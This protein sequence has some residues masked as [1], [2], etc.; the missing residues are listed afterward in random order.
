MNESLQ[1]WINKISLVFILLTSP[2]VFAFGSSDLPNEAYNIQCEENYGASPKAPSSVCNLD[3]VGAIVNANCNPAGQVIARIFINYTD[4]AGLGYLVINGQNFIPDNNTGT[5][6]FNILVTGDGTVQ[7]VYAEMELDP[8]CFA[9]ELNYLNTPNCG[10]NTGNCFIEIIEVDGISSCLPDGTVNVLVRVQYGNLGGGDIELDGNVFTPD[11]SGN[12]LFSINVLGDGTVGVD[13][14]AENT[15]DSSCNHTLV[16]AFNAPGCITCNVT[17]FNVGTPSVCNNGT[18]SIPVTLTYNNAAGNVDINGQIFTP[19]ASSGTE[20]FTLTNLPGNGTPNID[21][22]ATFTGDPNCTDTMLSAYNAPDCSCTLTI[23][24]IGTPSACDGSGNYSIGITVNYVGAQGNIDING[25]IFTPGG[26]SGTETFTLVNLPGNGA[27]NLPVTA[28]FTGDTNCTDTFNNAYDAPD[29]NCAITVVSVG[30]PSACDANGNFSINVTVSYNSP[31]GGDILIN[32]Q[33]FTPNNSGFE[34][35][36]L[37]NLPGDGSLDI[38]VTAFFE[39]EPSCTNTLID[40]FDAPNCSCSINVFSVGTP[41]ACDGNGNYTVDVTVIWSNGTGTEI[42]IEGQPFTITNPLSGSDVFTIT[43]PGNGE[44][45]VDID[46]WFTGQQGTCSDTNVDAYNAPNCSCS[47]AITQVLA[48]SACD[49]NGEYTIGIRLLYSNAPGDVNINGQIFTPSAANGTEIFT[50]TGLTGDGTTNI[51]VNAF[52]VDDP[53]CSDVELNAYNAPSCNCSLTITSVGTPSNCNTGGNFSV[54]VTVSYTNPQGN[55]DINGQL[56]VP[57]G[58]GNETFTLTGIPGTGATGIDVTAF[59]TSDTNCTDTFVNAYD[60]PDCNCSLTI[61]GIGTPSACDANGQFSVDVTVNYANPVGSIVINGQSFTVDNSGSE[62]FTL[63]NL[64][65]DGTQ[66]VDVT[67]FFAGQTSCTD[68]FLD[69]FNAPDCICSIQ[70]TNV[71]TPVCTSTTEYSVDVTVT[72]NNPQGS[73]DINGQI[74]TPNGSGNETFTLTNLLANGEIGVDISASFTGDPSCLDQAIDAF[75][76]PDCQQACNSIT[77]DVVTVNASHC[78][79]TDGQVCFTVNGG[80]PPYVFDDYNYVDGNGT[81]QVINF[82]TINSNGVQVCTT[83]IPPITLSTELTDDAGCTYNLS[84]ITINTNP[85]GTINFQV[86]TTDVSECDTNDGEA[87]ITITGSAGATGPFSIYIGNT[88]YGDNQDGVE[89]CLQNLTANTYNFEIFD[90]NGCPFTGTFPVTINQQAAITYS[91]TTVDLTACNSLDGEICFTINGGEA[92]YELTQGGTNYGLFNEGVQQ[93]ITG[94]DGGTY[95]ILITDNRNCTEFATGIVLNEPACPTCDIVSITVDDVSACDAGNYDLTVT[96]SIVDPPGDIDING[97]VFPVIGS[98]TQQFVL[99]DIVGDGTANIDIVAFFVDEPTCTETLVDAYDEPDCTFQTQCQITVTNIQAG[100]CN[101]NGEFFISIEY[102]VDVP[103][104]TSFTITSSDGLINYGSFNYGATVQIGP[105]IGD[106]TTDYTF[107]LTDDANAICTTNTPTITAPQCDPCEF[108]FSN[109][110]PGTC[111]ANGFFMLTVGYSTTNMPGTQFT[112][113]DQNSTNYGTFNYG[114]FV[115]IGP[116]LGDGS[117]YVFTATDNFDPSCDGTSAN[118]TAPNCLPCD[119]TINN[120]TISNCDANLQFTITIDYSYTN[121]TSPQFFVLDQNSVNHGVFNYGDPVVVG[122]FNGDG[123]TQYQFTFIDNTDFNCIETSNF[124]TAP[125]CA[126]NCS[127]LGQLTEVSTAPYSCNGPKPVLLAESNDLNIAGLNLIT[128]PADYYNT[129]TTFTVNTDNNLIIGINGNDDVVINGNN[130]V[131]IENGGTDTVTDNGTG[132]S[133]FDDSNYT[134]QWLLNGNPIAGA[135]QTTYCVTQAGNYSVNVI[136]TDTG[137]DVTWSVFNYTTPTDVPNAGS[138]DAITACSNNVSVIIDLNTYLSGDADAGGTWEAVSTINPPNTFV[139]GVFDGTGSQG[140]FNFR[141]IVET[142]YCG[143]DTSNFSVDLVQEPSFLSVGDPGNVCSDESF[144][145]TAVV[146]NDDGGTLE[147]FEVGT[148]NPV[149]NAANVTVT[150]TGCFSISNEYY[151]VYT[152]ANTLCNSITSSNVLVTVFPEIIGTATL[153]ADS[154]EVTLA[155]CSNFVVGWST[156]GTAG[157]GTTFTA[158]PGESGQV[159]FTITNTDPN[160]PAGCDSENV[161]SIYS[162]ASVCNPE[163]FNSFAITNRCANTDLDLNE[164]VASNLNGG[165]WT[166]INGNPTGSTTVTLVNN[167]CTT[168]QTMY[169]TSYEIV[170]G[171]GCSNFYNFD[172]TVN[173]YPEITGTVTTS[174]DQCTVTINTCSEFFVIWDDGN[175]SSVGNTYT[176]QPGTSGTVAFTVL[177]QNGYPPTGCDQVVFANNLYNCDDGC[178]TTIQNIN[179]TLDNCSDNVVDLTAYADPAVFGNT[180][181]DPNGAAVPNPSNLVISNTT[182]QTNLQQYTTSYET[183]GGDG[184]PIQNNLFLTINTYPALAYTVSTSTDSCTVSLLGTCQN[185]QVTWDDGVNTGV[186]TTY[187]ATSNTMGNVVFT[188]TNNNAPIG[189]ACR[190]MMTGD[191]PYNCETGCEFQQV[192]NQQIINVCSE[193]PFDL[194]ALADPAVVGAPWLDENGATV[195]NPSNIIITNTTCDRVKYDYTI[196]YITQDANGCDVNNTWDVTVNVFPFIA[197]NITT[198]QDGCQVSVSTCPGWI[199]IWDDGNNS[200]IGFTYNAQQGTSGTVTFTVAN[201]K[202]YAPPGCAEAVFP[203][204]P[205]SCAANCQPQ[206]VTPV[207]TTEACSGDVLD[208]TTIVDP[209]IF[210]NIWYDTLGNSIADP[211][212]VSVANTDCDPLVYNFTTTFIT[213]DANGCDITNDYTY[214]VSVYPQ[215]TATIVEDVPTCTYTAVTCPGYTVFVDDGVQSL[216]TNVY[217]AANG[218]SGLITF[219]VYNLNPDVP[220][221]CQTNVYADI[222]YSCGVSCNNPPNSANAIRNIC[223]GDTIIFTDFVPFADNNGNW[224]DVNNGNPIPDTLIVYENISCLSENYEYSTTY[225]TFDNQGCPTENTFNLQ[226]KVVPEITASLTNDGCEIS[227]STCSDF[228]VI[229]DD[230]VNSAASTNYTAAQGQSGIVTFTVSNF[231]GYVPFECSSVTF[232][233]NFNCPTTCDTTDVVINKIG[234][235]CSESFTNLGDYVDAQG[236]SVTWYDSLGVEI[237]DPVNVIYNNIGC[238]RVIDDLSGVYFTTGNDGCP[239]RNTIELV[240][241]IYPA[242]SANFVTSNDGCTVTAQTCPNF[243]VTWNDGATS[244]TGAVYDAPG[245]SNGQVTFTISN[246]TSY[247]PLE[248]QIQTFAPVPFSCI[249]CPEAILTEIDTTVCSGTM[250]NLLP[251]APGVTSPWF[252]LQGESYSVADMVPQFNTG[253]A[254]IEKTYITSTVETDENDCEFFH[255][256][257]VYVHVHPQISEISSVIDNGCVID[258]LT[259]AAYSV[260]WTDSEGNTGTGNS[261]DASVN[262]GISVTFHVNN[263]AGAGACENYST[264]PI[265]ITNCTTCNNPPSPTITADNNP[266]C[267]AG[268]GTP[269]NSTI[270]SVD[271]PPSGYNYQWLLNGVNISAAN[272]GNNPTI[273]VNAAGN[274]TLIFTDGNGCNSL[275]SNSVV[276]TAVNCSPGCTPPPAPSVIVDANPI[277]DAGTGTPTSALFS[278]L[279]SPPAGFA[280]QWQFNGINIPSG[281]GGNGTTLTTTSAGTYTLIFTDGNGCESPVSNSIDL[282]SE[283]CTTCTPPPAPTILVD[284][285]PFCQ[286]GTGTPNASTFTTPNTPPGGYNYQWQLNGFDLPASLGGNSATFTIST[287]G[288]YTLFFEDASGNGCDSPIS[289]SIDLTFI[290]CTPAC[291][292]PAAPTINVDVNPIC[293]DGTGTPTTATFSTFDVPPT[294]FTYQWQ[295]NGFDLAGALGGNNAT[296]TADILGDY[297]LVFINTADANCRTVVSNTIT[298]TETDCTPVCTPPAQ[299]VISADI[300]PICEVGTGNPSSAIISTTATPPSGFIYQWQF[301]GVDIL[302][303]MGGNN[304]SL[305]A[306]QAGTYTLIFTD[307]NGCDSPFSNFLILQTEDC[308]VV[309]IAPNAPTI[310]ADVNPICDAGTGSPETAILTA[311]PAPPTGYI[312]QWYLNGTAISG[313]NGGNSSSLTAATTGLY[314]LAYTDGSGCD[315]QE[316]NAILLSSQDCT[317][318]CTTPNAPAITVDANPICDAGTG[319]PTS[320]TFSTSATLPTGFGY[321]WQLNGTD[322]V[323]A[324]NA[325]YNTSTLGTYTLIITDG[326]GCDSPSSNSITLLTEDCNNTTPCDAYAGT[327]ALNNSTICYGGTVIGFHTDA[328]ITP[329]YYGTV[330]LLY[331]TTTSVIEVVDASASFTIYQFGTFNITTLVYNSATFDIGTIVTG[332][333][334]INDVNAQLIQGGGTICGSLEMPGPSVTV[335]DCTDPCDN[336]YTGINVDFDTN[337]IC[338]SGTGTPTTATLST[339]GIALPSGYQ[340]QWYLNGSALP[341]FLGGN[342]PTLTVASPGVYDVTFVNIGDP[343]CENYVSTGPVE[344]FEEDCSFV[345][346]TLQ[347][348]VIE[349]DANP[350]CIDGT[351]TP[352]M[353]TLSTTTVLPSNFAYQWQLNGINISSGSGGASP[354]ITVNIAATYT[355]YFHD[356]LNDC[357]SPISNA[358]TLTEVDCT[359]TC[360]PPAAPQITVDANPICQQGTGSPESAV[361]SASP[362]P[363]SGF[364][365]QWQL[366]GFNIPAANGGNSATI[367]TSDAGVYTLIFTDGASCESLAS[368]AISLT[369]DDC[370][371]TCTPPAAPS[372]TV[373]ANPICQAGTGSPESAIFGT[374]DTPPSGYLY[375]WQ[376]N[377]FD[378]PVGS[379]GNNP[380]F[381]ATTDGI[382]TLMFVDGNGCNSAASNA[383]SLTVEDCTPVCNPPAAPSIFVDANPI[384]QAGTGTPDAANLSSLTGLP[385]GYSYQWQLNGVD[386]PAIN[387]GNNASISVNAA[388]TYTLLFIDGNGCNSAA[389]NAIPLTVDDCTPICTPPAAPSILVTAN[390]ICMAGTGQPE[391]ATF[392]SLTTLP[393]GYTYQWQFNGIDIPAAMGG[394]NAILTTS[395]VG[396][397]T[398]IFMDGNGCDSPVSNA[399]TITMVDCTPVCTPPQPPSIT[400]DTNPICMAGTGTP[401]SATLSTNS[402]PPSGFGYQWLLN[403]LVIS[404]ET[405]ASLLTSSAGTYTL[406]FTDGANCESTESNSI[407]L[408]VANCT[409]ACTPPSAPTITINN[410]PICISGTGNPD[411][412]ILSTE[413]GLPSGFAYQW[414]FNGINIPAATGGNNSFITTTDAGTYTL[415]IT[416][417]AGCDSPIS[418]AIE[419]VVNDCTPACVP[420]NAPI[421]NI[422]NSTIC[423]LGTGTPNMAVLSTST[424]LPTG[425]TYQWMFN[426]TNIPGSMGGNSASFTTT[427]AG[428]YTLILTDGV[429]C[430]SPVS[431]NIV[432]VV[433]DCTTG[434]TPPLAPSITIDSNPI[435]DAGTGTPTTATLSTSSTPPTGFTYQWMFN[436]INIP[437]AM[438]GNTATITTS[439]AGTYTLILTNG[440]DCEST[441]SNSIVLAVQDCTQ[442][443]IPPLAPLI[444]IDA[445]IICDLGTGSPDMATLSVLSTL[446]PGYTYQWFLNGVVISAANGGNNATITTSNTGTYNVLFTDNNGCDSDLSN[447]ITLTSEDCST[448]CTPPVA[449]TISADANPICM[450]GTGEPDDAILSVID[451]LPVGF[452]YQWQYNGVDISAASGGTNSTILVDEAGT[453]TLYFTNGNGCHSPISNSINLTLTDCTVTCPTIETP[454]IVVNA[455]PICQSGT[456]SPTQAT[457]STTSVLPAGY[458]YYWMLNGNVVLV[459]SGGSS[460]SY[461]TSV[462]GNY[463]LMISNGIDCESGISNTI[464]ITVEDCTPECDPPSAPS[465]SIDVN[466]ICDLG[467]G[468]PETAVLMATSALPAGYNYQWQLNG[469]NISVANGGQNANLSTNTL[470]T[471]TLTLVNGNGCDSQVSNAITLLTE[472]CSPQNI[473]LAD[474][475]SI[476]AAENPI[477]EDE[478]LEAVIVIPP[479]I[480]TGFDL[481]YLL[482]Q[483]GSD[484]IIQTSAL[485]SFSLAS[486]GGYTIHTLVYDPLSLDISTLTLGVTTI[487]DFNSLLIQGG[488]TICGSLD[489]LGAQITVE[490]CEETIPDECIPNDAGACVITIV[491]IGDKSML[492]NQAATK[493]MDGTVCPNE[494]VEV[495]ITG[496][497]AIPGYMSAYLIHTVENDPAGSAIAIGTEADVFANDGS[498]PLIPL[499]QTIYFTSVIVPGPPLGAL[500]DLDLTDLCIDISTVTL[501]VMFE[502]EC[503]EEPIECD[504]PE[505]YF[506]VCGYDG[507]TYTNACYAICAGVQYYQGECGGTDIGTVDDSTDNPTDETESGTT[508]ETEGGTTDETE[509]STTDETEGGT[510]DET[511]GGT[512]DET[513]GGTTDE[514]ESSTTDETEGGTTDE[515]E[516]GTTDETEGGTTDETDSTDDGEPVYTCDDPYYCGTMFVCTTPMT[517]IIICP[518]D[519]DEFT[520]LTVVEAHSTFGCSIQIIDGCVRYIPLPGMELSGVDTVNMLA[521]DDDGNC[522]EINV[523]I[524][525]SDCQDPPVEECENETINLCT[526]HME[527]VVIC[528]E[529]CAFEENGLPYEIVDYTSTYGCSVYQLTN[530]CVRYT[531]LP[532]FYGSD[533]IQLIACDLVTGETCDTILVNVLVGDCTPNDPPSAIDD[534]AETDQDTPVT[535]YVMNNDSDPDGDDIEVCDYTQPQNGTVT[536][537]NGS[538]IYIPNDGYFGTD[539]FT[540]SICDDQASDMA[541]V[542]ITVHEV[543]DPTMSICTGHMTPIEFC[544]DFCDNSMM[545]DDAHTT[546]NCSINILSSTCVRYVPLPGYYGSDIIEVEGINAQGEEEIVIVNV[547]VG[548]CTAFQNGKIT[549]E[550]SQ[551]E[552]NW[553]LP[554]AFTPNNDGINDNFKL[555][556]DDCENATIKALNIF[557]MR[558]Q[559]VY[560]SQQNLIEFKWEGQSSDNQRLNEGTYLYR[561]EIESVG[562]MYTH[563]GFIELRR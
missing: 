277:C 270:S 219:T 278:S 224:I 463:T 242:L 82:T 300:N 435:C 411:L 516:G 340:H 481:A 205:Y 57:N 168:L 468:S 360:T 470:G 321:Q 2:I 149:V 417:G 419:L 291:D 420:P 305:T 254:V 199:V 181:L 494:G 20:T 405:N 61:T 49:A 92:P 431:N 232:Q 536:L 235:I 31:P 222:P 399:I 559:Q 139:N 87:C 557:D 53:A 465:I 366:N 393:S 84:N 424:S 89:R 546:F 192:N 125:T 402:T 454:T 166:D 460:S 339:S 544:V 26:S 13:L 293:I 51:D 194:T 370:T 331:N 267:E 204:I 253:C 437:A 120:M 438:G 186:D 134:Y 361:F 294:G 432:L 244:G 213:Q 152:P 408:I 111:D 129:N 108:I 75:D 231:K 517:P 525:I 372:I 543:C 6:A 245:T 109:L 353:A 150:N 184:C 455:N 356:A 280:Y 475:G 466:P 113:T 264:N 133:I 553:K 513:E 439:D 552:C 298:L 354:S 187:L 392:N 497:F 443:C 386:I 121:P 344:I 355:L 364:V 247:A 96:L 301:N 93:C 74:F 127:N 261:Y 239:V 514:T 433:E 429:D 275:S 524:E 143:S 116:I 414:M 533:Y 400:I 138:D 153:S 56:F 155:T 220:P 347:A 511:E 493:M 227:L 395:D 358:I 144:A 185:F 214:A 507:I 489:L 282:T 52:F 58:S 169:F 202:D 323:G 77:V 487:G 81:P 343:S 351:G 350:I 41:S 154:C 523:V 413:D 266:I 60:E 416:D 554:N 387:G 195:N 549:S 72:Y 209:A 16:D 263:P 40:A 545:V 375:Q 314:T 384:C 529:F 547:E 461:T 159:T 203:D 479:T 528:P 320:A 388:G 47:L 539:A 349:I 290:D 436:G 476:I 103:T 307:G 230:G 308:N 67:A 510:T 211:T 250:L 147:W 64:N 101:S 506:P 71:A 464:T 256:F 306:S 317:G 191:L 374:P 95:N 457:L 442:G 478:L 396:T 98:G 363:P 102:T 42:Q 5:E 12:E 279:S 342:N 505:N 302:P 520:D 114:D 512:T 288:V 38:D 357:S 251:F 32:G 29:C 44:L 193:E 299:P 421:I 259:C 172:L 272:G 281:S 500:A 269:E 503:E 189:L 527:P 333:T 35:F 18:Y 218:S 237:T 175:N 394:N 555:Q 9:E 100:N 97:Y 146:I 24:G 480:P 236:V 445:N 498:N 313:A 25:Q 91:T 327:L 560:Q 398:L 39:T 30:N 472:D 538:F 206:T 104:G 390:P 54:D 233:E 63:V 163:T 541:I 316:S 59:F 329:F 22:T 210:G 377:G 410:N 238:V 502:F 69:A 4:V 156:G 404:G 401:V 17:V 325:T 124:I 422:D 135:N 312:Y 297:T 173:I 376:L 45:G 122:P 106:G 469:A 391:T 123:T 471:Y 428:T 257:F 477:C 448:A 371:P 322:I 522:V 346:P 310:S 76:E 86:N 265:S 223:S 23:T 50:L 274:Y 563:T 295:L 332:T 151:A 105:L 276:I 240:L 157:S 491:E 197:A 243:M 66:N 304:P 336:T 484:A 262:G 284:V 518:D 367:A 558:G 378:L 65:G 179:E 21:V 551:L 382:Y 449:P 260:S 459:T 556:A 33:A 1:S 450:A 447:G 379:G 221:A 200:D 362:T 110:L 15:N 107:T 482:T 99:Q 255:D 141:Y 397:Y 115:Q 504:C 27:T 540:Y 167:G 373:T 196:T 85:Q 381:T 145:L 434:C 324:T 535:I 537:I 190:T 258:Y 79:A 11:G 137:C 425:F 287:T 440:I 118:F 55:I 268:T 530:D 462:A 171:N 486:L 318:L 177:S 315:S 283:D 427:D 132:N 328:P 348:P 94:L 446:P 180:W 359:P 296:Y 10:G 130:N 80:T 178:T 341:G 467:T 542:D 48:P 303:G 330:Y 499:G 561:I 409:P 207:G 37:T 7:D 128:I 112:I 201:Y 423:Q 548:D 62:T 337:T 174:P 140:T 271:T 451:A 407:D 34:T 496:D 176:A 334:T 246:L 526:G 389:S 319:T 531:P 46:A 216:Q 225:T 228:I 136:F 490:E 383:I 532:G 78:N 426:G 562:K 158:N 19:S 473:C 252:N 73:I 495:E 406:V 441:V 474:A 550:I 215:I 519:C 148:N 198:S 70:I 182:C 352:D 508:D 285:N 248:C 161:S 485:P 289:N 380:S 88:Y 119:I 368:N 68:T 488:G 170:D 28:T 292:P 212:S 36:T 217:T 430:T 234:N 3:I 483:N 131:F 345:C 335:E 326:N 183:T 226:V 273:T 415:M 521:V 385:T 249:D 126:A 338:E 142:V 534:S 515:T 286:L 43:M 8:S 14:Y 501:P 162:C 117:N 492:A 188:I 309:C 412:A 365:Y 208:L 458:S 452:G 83:G 456:G 241:N 369:V 164:Y 90:G 165:N 229:W 509:S 311:N 453:Y 444:T 160:V 403:G 418:N